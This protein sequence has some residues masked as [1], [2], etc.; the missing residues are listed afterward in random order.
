MIPSDYGRGANREE[1]H[2]DPARPT[3]HLV[4]RAKEAGY[5][6]YWHVTGRDATLLPGMVTAGSSGHS[7]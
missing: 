6:A 2:A 3:H 7:L 5:L 4:R 1:L